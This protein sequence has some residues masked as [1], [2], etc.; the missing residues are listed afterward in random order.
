[1]ICECYRAEKNFLGEVGTCW[2]TAERDACSC[3]GDKSKC[4]FYPSVRKEEKKPVTNYD[5]LVRKSPEE[6]AAWISKIAGCCGNDYCGR[7]CPL[8]TLCWSKSNE[9]TLDWLKQEFVIDEVPTIQ[10][11]QQT[12][13]CID[14]EGFERCPNCGVKMKKH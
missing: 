9:S 13:T 3:G 5:S 6:L 10:I 14:S 8:H 11:N 4:D 12:S 7:S 2:G 1:M